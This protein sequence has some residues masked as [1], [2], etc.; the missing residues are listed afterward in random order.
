METIHEKVF[1]SSDGL[2][3][4]NNTVKVLFCFSFYS[5]YLM[6]GD[7]LYANIF[8]SCFLFCFVEIFIEEKQ[9]T[10]RFYI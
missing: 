2:N 10:Q 1:I 4:T 8:Q 7:L 5:M 3:A 9:L 6:L